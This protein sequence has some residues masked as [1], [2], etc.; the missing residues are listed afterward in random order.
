MPAPRREPRRAFVR[1][2][3][4]LAIAEDEHGNEVARINTVTRRH[5]IE[6]LYWDL[7]TLGFAP[8]NIER[9]ELTG[10]LFVVQ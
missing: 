6:E 1:I 7:R 5:A 10:R 9:N 2:E 8:A 4:P 3:P